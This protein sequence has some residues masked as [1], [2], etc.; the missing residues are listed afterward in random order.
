LG[1]TTI[2]PDKVNQARH[3]HF[4]NDQAGIAAHMDKHAALLSPR[5][6]AVLSALEAELGDK[7][8][9]EWT[10]PQGGYFVSFDTLPGLAADVVKLAADAGVKLTPAGATW[11][12]GRDPQDTNIR[13][14][15]SF[16]SVED[17]RTAMS[18]FTCCVKLATTRK[19]LSA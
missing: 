17:I 5:F 11:P 15:P 3:V 8:M 14:A 18:V 19:L 7:T 9:G 16:P 10:V 2:G 13:L 1:K 12:Y 6:D 4:L